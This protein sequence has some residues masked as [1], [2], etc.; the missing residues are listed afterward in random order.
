MR[1]FAAVAWQRVHDDGVGLGV[2][3]DYCLVHLEVG[4]ITFQLFIREAL[5]LHPSGINY[6][7]TCQTLFQRGSLLNH[8]TTLARL[9][10]DIV[11]HLKDRKSTR[12]N[13]SHVKT[14]YAVF[15]LKKK[16]HNYD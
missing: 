8:M 9:F 6:I 1:P 5:L 13:S 2:T 12:L 4:R 3:V 16:A 14:S 11:R 7:S 10:K 15:C